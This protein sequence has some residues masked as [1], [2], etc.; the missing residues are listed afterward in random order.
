MKSTLSSWKLKIVSSFDH[1]RKVSFSS[2]CSFCKISK[3]VS[4]GPHVRLSFTT[5][6]KYSYISRDSS[7]VFA[8]IGR[9][10]SIG[11]NTK[12]GQGLHPISLL[13]TS[14]FLYSCRPPVAHHSFCSESKFSEHTNI[15]ESLRV[16]IGND[17]LIGANVTIADGVSIGHGA[18][19][20]YG[21]YVKKNVMPYEIVAGVPAKHLRYRFDK[22]TISSLLY[23]E[24]WNLSD[25]H[26]RQ[27]SK[28][29]N[30]L[31]ECLQYLDSVISSDEQSNPS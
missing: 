15:S 16:R 23:Y 14:P 5:I 26:I 20:G 21:S 4:I 7:A 29:I 28:R 31:A 22:N 27:I 18:I 3:G 24:W 13:S 2:Q 8:E 30:S 19:V 25:L 10:T 12:I 9:F 17:V 1:S 6:D 11:P